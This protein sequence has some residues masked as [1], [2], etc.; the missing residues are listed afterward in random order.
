MPA[1]RPVPP[2]A[3]E[4]EPAAGEPWTSDELL[5]D[6]IDGR[7]LE[8]VSLE[9]ED[10]VGTTVVASVLRR[11]L[12]AGVDLSRAH[13]AD[14][15]LD[16][17]DAAALRAPRSTWRS[18]EVRA[19]RLG[20]TELYETSWRT[21]RVA[22][23]K[24]DYLNARGSTWQDVDL[25]GCRVGELDL[26]DARVQR[27]RLDGCTVESLGLRG[28]R[29]ADVDLRGARIGSVEGLDGLAGTWITAEQLDGLAPALAD[30]L[31]I[32]VV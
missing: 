16:A 20:A 31:G 27:L 18:C 11:C 8:D 4:V 10:L 22:H 9:D 5:E 1:A 2:Q 30:Q 7:L 12:L 28:A 6:G 21:V 17:C 14:A 13:L 23:T 29:L 3:P 32:R 25:V 15:L 19:S 26:A 24:I